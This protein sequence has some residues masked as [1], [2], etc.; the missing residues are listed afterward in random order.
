MHFETSLRISHPV[1][2]CKSGQNR[3]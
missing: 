2:S 1:I 3:L